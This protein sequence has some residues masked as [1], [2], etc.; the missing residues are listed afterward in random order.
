MMPR[1]R[2]LSWVTAVQ[3]RHEHS[4][5]GG[6]SKAEEVQKDEQKKNAKERDTNEYKF[7][8]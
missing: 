5:A 2:L 3:N 6:D 7:V 4:G 1:R 8:T